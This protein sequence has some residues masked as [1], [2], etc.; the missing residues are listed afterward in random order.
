MDPPYVGDR[1]EMGAKPKAFLWDDPQ[2]GVWGRAP[3]TSPRGSLLGSSEPIGVHGS[4]CL[5]HYEGSRLHNQS[6]SG[7][8]DSCSNNLRDCH[9]VQGKARGRAR[10]PRDPVIA[11][12]A[13]P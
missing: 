9:G 3:P 4:S 10:R 5:L 1:H 8:Q 6:F 2:R 11:R 7:K 12:G 13:P